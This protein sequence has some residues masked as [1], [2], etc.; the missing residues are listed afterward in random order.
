MI[1]T[2][3]RIEIRLDYIEEILFDRVLIANKANNDF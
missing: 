1:L 2:L 3:D